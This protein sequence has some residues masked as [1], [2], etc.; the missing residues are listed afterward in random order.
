M[1]NMVSTLV[2]CLNNLLKR[3]TLVKGEIRPKLNSGGVMT[4]SEEL[5]N[6]AL[7]I[8]Y[9]FAEQR[10]RSFA[11]MCSVDLLFWGRGRSV[12]VVGNRTEAMAEAL[13]ECL[14]AL[15]FDFAEAAAGTEMA[16]SEILK[17]R[18]AAEEA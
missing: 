5:L 16:I 1:A 18:K 10:D 6:Q 9:S 14:V 15:S 3:I 13:E 12:A 11:V 8:D 7:S 17:T 4:T 2:T